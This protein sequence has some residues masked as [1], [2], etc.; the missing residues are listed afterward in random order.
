MDAVRVSQKAAAGKVHTERDDRSPPLVLLIHD[1]HS[2]PKGGNLCLGL[3]VY[4]CINKNA[5]IFNHFLC[6]YVFQL[7]FL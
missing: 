7:L 1:I 2:R 3:K 5:I 6:F 4:R